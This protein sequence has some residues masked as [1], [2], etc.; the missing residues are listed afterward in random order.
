MRERA[1]GVSRRGWAKVNLTLA[2]A[3]PEPPEAERAGWHRIASWMHAIEL[4]DD[5]RVEPAAGGESRLVVRWA[6]DAARPTAIDWGPEDDLVEKARR[7]L[8][9]QVGV[10]LPARVEVVKRIPVGAGLGG[11]S[12]DAAAALL[13][14]DEAFG[15]G[16][17]MD[18]L[19]AVG[20]SIGSDVPFFLDEEDPPRPAEVTGFGDRIERLD[21]LGDRWVALFVPDFGCE[22]RAVYRAFDDLPRDEPSGAGVWSSAVR[23]GGPISCFNALALAAERVR[24]ELGA[25]R[26]RL[27]EMTGE[28]VHVT[29]SG[30]AM[31]IVAEDE[32]RAGGLADLGRGISGVTAMP[33]R[34]V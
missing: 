17:S 29:G 16:L 18:R 30:S 12:S 15:L 9:R 5:V 4:H 6:C 7:A 23:D 13:A 34:L 19:Q 21:R 1:R 3:P 32:A 14:L 11:G 33:A 2:V 28:G 22:T 10:D 27:G 24:P 25:L 31:F 8:E 26:A 20:A